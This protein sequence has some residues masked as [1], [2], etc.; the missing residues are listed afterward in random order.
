MKRTDLTPFKRIL[1]SML[2][3]L[4]QPLHSL[5]EISIE[6]SPDM[7]EQLQ[8][9]RDRELAIH[10]LEADSSRIHDVTYALQRIREDTYGLCAR[11]E[12]E[13]SIKRLNAVPWANYCLECQRI[14]DENG[15]QPEKAHARSAGG[16]RTSVSRSR[17]LKN[18]SS[19]LKSRLP[20]VLRKSLPLGI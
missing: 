4:K 19:A 9:A 13:I 11:C 5:E 10:R 15:V 2:G 6:N 3:G 16:N 14:A 20:R 12:A 8:G 1:E 17:E 7:L 18:E